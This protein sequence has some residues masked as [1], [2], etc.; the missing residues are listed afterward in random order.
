[1][2]LNS[3][4]QWGLHNNGSTGT[5][6]ADIKAPEAW[7][8]ITGGNSTIVAVVDTGVDYLH[9]DLATNMW[10]NIADPINGIDDD[11]NGFIDDYFGINTTVTPS[12]G[13]PMDTQGHGTAMAGIIGAVGNNT[14]GIAGVNWQTRIMALKFANSGTSYVDNAITFMNYARSQKAKRD[15]AEGKD[16]PMVMILGWSQAQKTTYVNSL[17]DALRIAQDAGVLVVIAAGND[18]EDTDIFPNYPSSYNHDVKDFPVV[19]PNNI[20]LD[21]IISVG[22]SDQFDN[23][24]ATS[25]YGMAT[26][27]LFAP[28]KNIVTTIPGNKYAQLYGN[29]LRRGPCGRRLRPPVEPVSRQGLEADQGHGAER[30]GGWHGTGFSRHLRHRRPLE[31][32]QFP[33]SGHR[34]CPGRLLHLR[35]DPCSQ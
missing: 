10:V 16:T 31:P 27:D 32:G 29:L 14:T 6:G 4:T 26:V 25:S 13:D 17:H 24:E 19:N 1:M 11:T 18:N 33:A 34:E 9:E 35:S 3:P 20:N 21:N 5:A 12:N 28:G 22:A 7:D 15:L 8:I 23:K 30:C 2:I